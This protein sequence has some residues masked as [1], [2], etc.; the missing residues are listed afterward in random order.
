[1]GTGVK[2]AGTAA[3]G[4]VS[5]KVLRIVGGG[6]AM[7]M[8]IYVGPDGLMRGM[9]SSWGSGRDGRR[10]ESRL[11]RLQPAAPTERAAFAW[12]PPYGAKPYSP[13]AAPAVSA[14]VQA[15]ALLAVG[16]RAPDF[17]LPQPSGGKLKFSS[18]YTA[19]RVTLLNF[20]SYF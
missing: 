19:N 3:I 11:T 4:G 5:C 2:I 12:S 20:W 17:E 10:Q 18:V 13:Q 6:P 9:S 8:T 7:A 14:S 16:A 15:P 1:M